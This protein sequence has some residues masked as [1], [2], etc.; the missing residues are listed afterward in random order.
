MFRRYGK[1]AFTIKD[2]G[3]ALKYLIYDSPKFITEITKI[4]L[5]NELYALANMDLRNM[6]ENT[7]SYKN[8]IIGG[9]SRYSGWALTAPDY[10]NRMSI[11]LAQMIHD[12]T[13]DAHY[14]DKDSDGIERLKYDMEKDKRFDVYLKYKDHAVPDSVKSVYEK[15][16]G[17]YIAML[18]QFNVERERTGEPLYKVGD[19][20]EMAY[21]VLQRESIKSFADESFGYYD[22]ETKAE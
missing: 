16:Y 8:G 2:Y 22:L 11:F 5:L 9:F 14:I 3:K 13:F 20:F 4:E 6:V 18:R 12:G 17:L 1:E 7:I 19:K 21:T 15:Q 10:W